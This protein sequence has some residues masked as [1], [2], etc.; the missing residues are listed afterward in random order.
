MQISIDYFPS[1]KLL[2]VIA[3]AHHFFDSR[4]KYERLTG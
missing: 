1:T 4:P 2:I 3:T